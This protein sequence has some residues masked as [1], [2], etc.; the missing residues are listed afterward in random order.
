MRAT[1]SRPGPGGNGM[2]MA[3]GLFGCQACAATAC[4]SRAAAAPSTIAPTIRT[5]MRT[6]PPP[7]DHPISVVERFRQEQI[8]RLEPPFGQAL[9]V[10]VAQERI[11]RLVVSFQAI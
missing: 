9:L 3:I 1:R 7:S 11:E 5:V 10:M 8:L 4:G 2:T 6:M